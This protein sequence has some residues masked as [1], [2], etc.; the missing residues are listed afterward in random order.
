[1]TP[2]GEET[3]NLIKGTG[4]NITGNSGST[5][6]SLTF[7]I[8]AALNDLSN[9]SVGSPSTNDVLKWNGSSWVPGSVSS[10]GATSLNGLSDV[11]VENNSIFLGSDPSSTTN[12]AQYNVAVGINALDSITEGDKN[13]AVGYDSLTALTTG[14]YNVASGHETLSTTTIGRA[15]VAIGYQSLKN[16]TDGDFNLSLIPISEP[17]RP[18]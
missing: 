4:I 8:N 7:S 11:L 1:M 14:E 6:Q 9:V 5:P 16:N 18:Y 3:L 2:S 10:G 15:N 17:T 13:V 12:N